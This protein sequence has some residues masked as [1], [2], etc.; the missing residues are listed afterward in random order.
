MKTNTKIETGR[1]LFCVHSRL[2][3]IKSLLGA[4][5][6]CLAMS[7]YPTTEPLAQSQIDTR[8]PPHF[9]RFVHNVGRF[10]LGVSNSNI[11]LG[12]LFTPVPPFFEFE[13]SYPKETSHVYPMP[14]LIV[15]G[16]KQ[17]DTLATYWT[18]FWPPNEIA[19]FEF[20]DS[21]YS[22]Q[23][24]PDNVEGWSLPRAEQ[25]ITVVY[26]D[27]LSDSPY[28]PRE[29]LSGF[30]HKPLG[31]RVQQTSMAWSYAHVEDIILF[32]YEI[33][34]ISHTPIEDAY[35]GIGFQGSAA[36]FRFGGGNDDVSG[37]IGERKLP[38]NLGDGCGP[39][40]DY[41]LAWG[42]DNNGDAVGD[43]P[44]YNANSPLA[45][46][47]VMI[48][49]PSTNLFK[50]GYNWWRTGE[51]NS[52]DFGPRKSAGLGTQVR[53]FPLG[54]GTP[55]SD[56]QFYH[57]MSSGE[58]D[59]G[60]VYTALNHQAAGWL[61][62]PQNAWSIAAGIASGQ[63]AALL[64]VG[65]FTIGPFQKITFVTA[66]IGAEKFHF[67]PSSVNP[68]NPK[69]WEARMGFDELV[70]NATWAK[71]TYDNPGV[72][73]DGDGY[74]GEQSACTR[75]SIVTLYRTV[76]DSSGVALDSFLVLDSIAG[77]FFEDT[78][79]IGGDGV[80]D[81]RA[82][83]PPLAPIVRYQPFGGQILLL[84]NGLQTETTPDL[85]TNEID[86][87]GYRT[88]IGLEKKS[89][90]MVLGASYDIENFI[91]WHY[92]VDV[93][94][95][96]VDLSHWEVLREPFSVAEAR[97]RYG[98]GKFDWHP[99]DYGPEDPFLFKDSLFFF[100]AQDWN[101]DNLLDTTS[102][103]KQYP[104]EPLPHTQ[105][106]NLAFTE[107]TWW[108]N[109]HTS[110]ETFY[111]GGELTPDGKYFKYYEYRFVFENLF[112]AQTYWVSVT[113][114]DQGSQQSQLPA[115]ETN[116]TFN[117]IRALAQD[118]IDQSPIDG[119]DV[120]VYPN[121]Y[122]VDA[123]YREQNFEGLGQENVSAERLREVHF[124]GLPPIC[125]ISIYSLDGDL[126]KQIDHN[127]AADDPTSMHDSWNVIT[128]NQQLP[129]SGIYYWV[130][131]TPEGLQQIGKLVL[132]M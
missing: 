126:I 84:W 82:A 32:E 86:F 91:Q 132:I 63:N 30:K 56:E 113:A 41:K 42:A 19:Q 10:N 95:P 128:R 77:F 3:S 26:Y 72:D 8:Y 71:W 25:E 124:T 1:A 22:F 94:G 44:V 53:Q 54:I 29:P 33:T 58:V 47:G 88:Y 50:F 67:S 38:P 60:Q 79:W 70:T 106:I 5:L 118:K 105:D 115:L 55:F 97:V 18:G 64:S 51:G 108:T 125:Q 6:L 129:V 100:V 73:T 78:I 49:S 39:M 52:Y 104:N 48:L 57:V 122:R 61:A 14:Y 11:S 69:G 116:P 99:G 16:I 114:I 109:P 20:G 68:F 110:V 13:M 2:G 66:Y 40:M 74:Y 31:I 36:G 121:P 81:Y 80:P 85:V 75:D 21:S 15:S 103:Y 45:A 101:N 87:E 98:K 59:Y 90:S 46:T 43:F 131:E 120:S 17:G 76:Y 27:T 96:S 83:I 89:H 102:I 107:D 35:L 93:R 24:D 117:A 34:N 23:V 12:F 7:A 127:T 62:P 4:V 28:V 65:P 9:E 112:P 119:L 92:V 130:V 37:F 123:G 111:E